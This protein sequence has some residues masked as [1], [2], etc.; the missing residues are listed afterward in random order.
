VTSPAFPVRGPALEAVIAQGLDRVETALHEA[1]S[2]ADPLVDAT[3]R[4][5]VEAGGKRLRPALTLLAAQLGSGTNDAVIK[6]AVAVELTHIASLYHD[7][8]MDSAPMRRG[9]PAAHEVWGNSVAIITGDVLFARASRLVADLG[10]VA[11]RIQAETFERLCLGQLHETVGP[12]EGAETLEHYLG[13]LA[14]KTASLI[15]TAARYG[16]MFAGATPEQTEMVAAYGHKVG[17]AFQLADDVLDLASDGGQSG[18]TPGTDLRERVPTMPVL[19]LRA[20]AAGPDSTDQ[21]RALLAQ[22]DA[23]L[24]SEEALAAAVAGLRGHPVLDETRER[25]SALAREA[26][27]EIAGLPDGEVKGSLVALA[28]ALVDRAS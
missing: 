11:V 5:L 1:V 16:A 13:V 10:P 23:D 9:M 19:L 15:S 3:S 20:R 25:A 18:K 26:V 27:D 7:D 21:D 14:D 22:L 6:A 2:H 24:S 28:A 12:E 17:V 4:H 8:V